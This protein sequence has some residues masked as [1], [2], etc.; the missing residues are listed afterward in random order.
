MIYV[1]FGGALGAVFRYVL[2]LN[3]P[4]SGIL[5]VSL[6]NFLGSV[7]IGI[8]FYYFQSKL[9]LLFAVGLCGGFT[10]FSSYSLELVKLL[11][12]GE[13]MVP[14][15]YFLGSNI[16]CVAGCY[17]GVILSRLLSLPFR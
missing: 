6:V 2:M 3:L 17:L 16:A 4:F 1:A 10:T 15:S 11:I 12:K 7:L 5:T 8:F 9:W 14:L 13:L